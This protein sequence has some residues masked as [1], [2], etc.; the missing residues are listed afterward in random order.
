M[1]RST[2]LWMIGSAL[3]AAGACAEGTDGGQGA[4]GTTGIAGWG[5]VG[6][7]AGTGGSGGMAGFG[8][9]AGGG[10]SGGSGGA[11]AAAGAG[12]AGGSAGGSGGG[13]AAT[14]G[15]STGGGDVVAPQVSSIL[16]TDGAVGV[17]ASTQPVITFS[18]AMTA[19]TLTV[20]TAGTTCSG[21]V[22]L[23]PDGFSS[24]VQMSSGSLAGTQYTLSPAAD[25][26][27]LGTYDVRVTTAA[28]DSAGNG[29]ASQFDTSTGFR[30]QYFHTIA[31]DGA[32][33]FTVATER[34]DTSTSGGQLYVAHDGANL[35]LGMEHVSI[36]ASGQGTGNKWVAF[37]VSEDPTLQT[38][39]TLSDD[40]RAQFGAAG[41][42]RMHYVWKERVDG[43][44]DTEFWVGNGSNWSTDWTTTGKQSW[45]SAGYVEASIA[46]SQIDSSC[47]CQIAVTAYLI[48]YD[49]DNGNGWLLNMFE[50]ATDGTGATPRPLVSYVDIPVPSSVAPTDGTL[51]QSF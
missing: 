26:L 2:R 40:G 13:G 7:D 23:S 16:P 21:S 20:N 41:T 48:D 33:D 37:L 43:G 42:Q 11:G 50:G 36:L 34:F 46:L 28:E 27:S 35:Y 47:P 30:A 22:Q 31:I 14:G 4:G 49:G 32:S 17:A 19:G 9:H 3:L 12:G 45:R 44:S 1:I 29:L 25:S 15:G 10:A 5:G 18:E 39:N 51:F 8:G 38:G 6:G 24:C